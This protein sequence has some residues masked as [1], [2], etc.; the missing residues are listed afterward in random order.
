VNFDDEGAGGVDFGEVS[1]AGL[2][3]DI[4][5]DAVGGIDNDGAGWS[6]RNLVDEGDAA[7]LEVF[8]DVAVVNDLVEDVN[9]RAFE[10]QYLIDDLDGHFD[11]GTEASGIGEKDFHLN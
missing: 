10:I 6:L 11:A 4:G 3:A 1:L 8:D 7:L 2:S 5:R 9:R